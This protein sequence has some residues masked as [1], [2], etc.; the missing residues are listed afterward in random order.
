MLIACKEPIA[1][2]A[3]FSQQ[4][5]CLSH[6]S[7]GNQREINSIHGV[8]IATPHQETRAQI[9]AFTSLLGQICCQNAPR[10][11]RPLSS[12]GAGM[13]RTAAHKSW[14]QQTASSRGG[15][16]VKPSL[17]QHRLC[18]LLPALD[19]LTQAVLLIF[20]WLTHAGWIWDCFGCSDCC[21]SVSVWCPNCK[22]WILLSHQCRQ[23]A[24][25]WTIYVSYHKK[26]C[27]WLAPI[28]RQ[29]RQLALLSSIKGSWSAHGH[30]SEL[31]SQLQCRLASEGI[32]TL[33]HP[34]APARTLVF[35][36]RGDTAFLAPWRRRKERCRESRAPVVRT[37]AAGEG[38]WR[39][40]QTSTAAGGPKLERALTYWLLCPGLGLALQAYLRAREEE[41]EQERAANEACCTLQGS[42]GVLWRSLFKAENEGQRQ[43]EGMAQTLQS[44]KGV[45]K[46]RKSDKIMKHY[47]ST[48]SA[49]AKQ[50]CLLCPSRSDMDSIGHLP[51]RKEDRGKR[52]WCSAQAQSTPCAAQL[53]ASCMTLF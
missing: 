31:W 30:T 5:S 33:T 37:P 50:K 19:C 8:W 12:R 48:L 51:G 20:L 52:A 44:E 29:G 18:N 15:R 38:S 47:A 1:S 17:L 4:K 10:S 21:C 42:A 53:L 24:V 32:S 45:T 25:D 46:E 3:F 34:V 23:H 6:H 2:T 16:A 35:S 36:T 22:R 13:Q 14:Q 39:R 26:K 43:V 41:K 49:W 7:M 11:A 27:S 9:N 28:S 40:G